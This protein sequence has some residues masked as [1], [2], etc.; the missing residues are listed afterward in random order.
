MEARMPNVYK[1]ARGGYLGLTAVEDFLAEGRLP[2]NLLEIIR[3]RASQIN[4]C[5]VCTDLHSHRARQAGESDER[6]WLLAAW[7]DTP[8]FTDAERAA[9]ALTEAITRIADDLGGVPDEVWE[10]ATTHFVDED[11][12]ALVMAIAS[13]N[14]WNRI[15]VTARLVAGTFR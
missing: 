13:V 1:L 9:L 15:N 14:A 2:R 7:R 4:G 12:A 5:S 11:L 6:L 8:F 10:Q 3:I